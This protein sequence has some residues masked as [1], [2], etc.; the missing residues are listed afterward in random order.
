MESTS[1]GGGDP[2]AREHGGQ[3]GGRVR[4][5]AGSV[6]RPRPKPGGLSRARWAGWAS[7]PVGP[8]G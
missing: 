5:W 2:A 4:G 3:R 7:R 1:D 8:G 6:I